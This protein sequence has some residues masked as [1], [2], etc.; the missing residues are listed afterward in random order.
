MKSN[1]DLDKDNK[2]QCYNNDSCNEFLLKAYKILRLVISAAM[3]IPRKIALILK[4]ILFLIVSPEKYAVL[5]HELNAHGVYTLVAV[6]SA[7]FFVK[8]IEISCF[9]S[10]VVVAWPWLFH[11]FHYAHT[12]F[13]STTAT[14]VSMKFSKNIIKSILVGFFIPPLFCT[15]SDIF[16]PYLGGKI[17]N[18]S[19]QFHLCIFHNAWILFGFMIG[20]VLTGLILNWWA[21]KNLWIVG[22]SSHFLHDFVST[23][24]SL[25]YLI[26]YGYTAWWSDLWIIGL[27]MI[28]AVAIP[29]MISDL[30]LPI[31]I[32]VESSVWEKNETCCK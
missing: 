6:I 25:A 8:L 12:F 21:K 3:F 9:K 18:I 24:A 15:I 28:V 23:I 16:M 31:L 14:L 10:N 19:M 13:A 7:I 30:V 29:C 20:G 22:I 2:K 4:S 11:T 26:G 27:L 17:F 1:R 32:S 5:F